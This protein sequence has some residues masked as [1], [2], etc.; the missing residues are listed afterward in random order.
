VLL[1]TVTAGAVVSGHA[2]RPA[3]GPAAAAQRSAAAVQADEGRAVLLRRFAV[4]DTDGNGMWQRADCD[5]LTAR[6]CG[7]FGHSPGS[8][9]A[10]AVAA[11]Q[12]ALFDALLAH[13]DTDGDQQI[14]PDEFTAA[15]GREMDDQAGFD[16]AVRAAARSLIQ[17]A[18]Q[19][20]SGTLDSGEYTRLAG[21]YGATVADAARAFARLDLDRNGVLDTTELTLAIAQFFASPDT[22]APGNLAFGRL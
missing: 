3:G 7:A 19:D 8:P 18:D 9:A 1:A 15:I 22:A 16:S 21:A 14:T 11:G 12:R 5:Q 4:V 20:G 13:M 10:L 6:L 2:A 17:A